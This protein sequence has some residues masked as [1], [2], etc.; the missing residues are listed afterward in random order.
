MS[1][2]GGVTSIESVYVCTW[3]AAKDFAEVAE[4]SCGWANG[5]KGVF[6]GSFCDTVCVAAP[7][8]RRGS[9]AMRD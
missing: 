7:G 5:K 9:V 6:P 8:D 4:M 1:W 3:E 2:L